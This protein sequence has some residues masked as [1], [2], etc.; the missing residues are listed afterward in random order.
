MRFRLSVRR[1]RSLAVA[2][3]MLAALSVVALPLAAQVS[4]LNYF[5]Q[6]NSGSRD[7]ALT[8]GGTLAVASTATVTGLVTGPSNATYKI[9]RGTITLDGSNPSSA[10]TGLTAIVACTTQL[11]Q[12]SA[13]AD[14]PNQFSVIT[15]AS[16]GRL[17]LYAWKNTG[18]TDPTMVA[19]TNNAALID[20][21]CLGT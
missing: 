3:L 6:P 4:V 18:G 9:A 7:N 8:I 15:D 2:C 14:D 16:A 5:S 21:I 1:L 11:K 12:S 20:W 13:P 10:T 19:S 17:D